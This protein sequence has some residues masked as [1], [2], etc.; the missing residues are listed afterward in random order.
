MG[1]RETFHCWQR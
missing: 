1:R